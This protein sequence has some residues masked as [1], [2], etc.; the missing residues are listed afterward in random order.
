MYVRDASYTHMVE[1]MAKLD[2]QNS[3]FWG[4]E[5]PDA[6]AATNGVT[7]GWFS[8]KGYWGG[9]D[10]K[11]HLGAENGFSL[12]DGPK[13]NVA[14]DRTWEANPPIYG[15]VRAASATDG[16][17]PIEYL[18]PTLLDQRYMNAKVQPSASAK[19]SSKFF[20]PVAFQ[21]AF[22]GRNWAAWTYVA[23]L[24]L[25]P[26]DNYGVYE[27][28]FGTGAVNSMQIV[29]N[30]NLV[31]FVLEPGVHEGYVS[32]IT[33]AYYNG[34]NWYG[35]NWDTEAWVVNSVYIKTMPLRSL[36]LQDILDV[37]TLPSGTEINFVIDQTPDGQF[38]GN[39]RFGWEKLTL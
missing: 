6:K 17:Y 13:M 19:D 23:K 10:D 1:G 37:S 39:P 30:G 4:V 20:S 36:N 32:D 8:A 33:I 7:T 16:I 27:G 21:G 22:A 35:Y 3:V 31:S 34:A 29:Q 24:G 18:D 26:D 28:N 38:S 12:L 9:D 5:Y 11:D 2:I 15:L 14:I 25:I